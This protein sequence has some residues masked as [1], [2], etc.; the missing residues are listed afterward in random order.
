MMG[1]NL[2]EQNNA[3]E[4]RM[5]IGTVVDNNDPKKLTRVK[6]TVLNLYEGAKELLP[7]I[8][9]SGN[10]IIPNDPKGS[11][12]TQIL[13]PPIGSE[14]IIV[15]QDGNP[16]YGMW[17]GSPLRKAVSELTSIYP[18]GYGFKDPKGNWFLTN[19]KTGEVKYIHNTGTS[20]VI[21]KDGAINV[22]SVKDINIHAD[23]DIRMTATNV[24]IN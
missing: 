5:F 10:G 12:G 20:I 4:G 6:A 18:F 14:I 24:H 17:P 11:Y 7:W 2:N 1:N 8:A 21:S 3:Y 22:R 9:P 13:P 15:L 19:T 23:G 16:Q